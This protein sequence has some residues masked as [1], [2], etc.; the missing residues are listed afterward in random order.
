MRA[1]CIIAHF[2]G[3]LRQLLS[4]ISYGRLSQGIPQN[5]HLCIFPAFL[6]AAPRGGKEVV[7]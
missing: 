5:V 3:L 4:M 7:G 1:H 6:A 2:I